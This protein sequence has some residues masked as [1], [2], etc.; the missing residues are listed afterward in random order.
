MLRLVAAAVLALL[1][2][3]ACDALGGNTVAVRG[4]V[5]DDVTGEPLDPGPAVVS[6]SGA[7][8]L[9]PTETPLQG[10][11]AADG[12]FDLSAEVRDGVNLEALRIGSAGRIEYPGADTSATAV[13]FGIDRQSYFTYESGYSRG[14]VGEVRLLPTCLTLGDVRL[15][16]PLAAS[17]Y[18]VLQMVPAQAVPPTTRLGGNWARVEE[19]EPESPLRLTGVGGQTARLEWEL[20]Q[21]SP[22]TGNGQSGVARGV[23]D[24]PIC[25]RHGVLRYTAT[26]PVP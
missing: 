21:F 18:L 23:V 11:A 3:S 16:R 6:V 19:G 4:R 26:V 20:N 5:V 25:P 24:L 2:L 10:E 17:E 8:F 9:G 14:N 15:S 1:V 12:R 7:S 22:P 13:A